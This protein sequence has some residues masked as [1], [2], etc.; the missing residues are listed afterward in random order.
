MSCLQG[1]LVEYP[2]EGTLSRPGSF[3]RG[4]PATLAPWSFMFWRRGGWLGADQVV[5]WTLPRGPTGFR[6]WCQ[7]GDV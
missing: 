4:F 1:R 5:A 2:Q 6:C 3:H 7:R